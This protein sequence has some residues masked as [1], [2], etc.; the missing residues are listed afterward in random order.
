[1]PRDTP[2]AQWLER[3]VERAA[4]ELRLDE[5][6]D[7]RDVRTQPTPFEQSVGACFGVADAVVPRLVRV[8]H[9]LP[10]EERR[11]LQ[12]LLPRVMFGLPAAS[13]RRD[14]RPE[15]RA[16]EEA[17]HAVAVLRHLLAALRCVPD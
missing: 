8:F 14:R 2:W 17:K 4:E 11:A 10:L 3:H 16:R 12:A 5:P 1:M 7:W 9:A 13:P 15:R 6:L